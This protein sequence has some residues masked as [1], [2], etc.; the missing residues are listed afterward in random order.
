MF[1][2]RQESVDD[3]PPAD[4]LRTVRRLR[5]VSEDAYPDWEAIYRDN[6]ERLYRLMYAKVGNRPDAEDLTT[7]V[8]LAALRPL[9]SSASVGEV[10]AYLLATARTVLAGHWRRTLGHEIST[11]DTD[12]LADVF[13]SEPAN[14]AAS[15]RAAQ[16]LAALP[17]RYAQILRL[18]FL[19]ACSLKEA[20]A[21]MRISV[22]NAKVLQFRALREAARAAADLP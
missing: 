17:P 11:I 1:V 19:Q 22:G 14:E 3:Q 5:V 21:Q 10:R 8:F 2:H 20:A 6:V 4:R 12:T 7:E 18:R 15:A 9:R 13:A 16:I